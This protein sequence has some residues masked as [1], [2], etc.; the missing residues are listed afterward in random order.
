MSFRFAAVKGEP[1]VTVRFIMQDPEAFGFPKDQR[2]VVKKG[3]KGQSLLEV[4]L[5][6]EPHVEIEHTCGGVCACSTC[7]VWVTKGGEYMSEA[8]DAENDRID[9]ARDVR[10]C[11]RLSCQ[12]RIQAE[13]VEI[14]CEIPAWN[15]NLVKEAPHD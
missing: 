7:H 6:E 12:A 11:S 1:N 9:Q 10:I 3:I 5:G 8:T 15:R 4:A 2:E 14:V 13:H